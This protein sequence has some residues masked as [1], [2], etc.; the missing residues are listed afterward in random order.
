MRSLRYHEKQG[1]LCSERSARGQHHY[2]EAAVNRVLLHRRPTAAA[3]AV[4]TLDRSPAM[5]HPQN[6]AHAQHECPRQM[7]KNRSRPT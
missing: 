2:D 6:W 4:P 3:P 5:C 1:M 7:P